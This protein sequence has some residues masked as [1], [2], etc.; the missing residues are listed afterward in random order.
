MSEPFDTIEQAD[1]AM[2]AFAADVRALRVKHRLADVYVVMMVPHRGDA[3]REGQVISRFS[4][5]DTLKSEAM[6]AWALGREQ[7]AHREFV[8]RLLAGSA[9]VR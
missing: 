4:M 3:G 8:E 1:A 5:G 6:V 9:D 2:D 7:A